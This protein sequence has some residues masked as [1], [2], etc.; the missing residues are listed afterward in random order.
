M[1]EP[2]AAEVPAA[3]PAMAAAGAG[4]SAHVKLAAFWPQNPALWFA[5]AECQFQVKGGLGSLIATAM[6]FQPYP[7]TSCSRTGAVWRP[8]GVSHMWCVYTYIYM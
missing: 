4:N 3:A 7:T 6:W 8:S 5:Q 2:Q 1:A